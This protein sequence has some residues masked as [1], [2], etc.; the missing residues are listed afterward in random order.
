MT[1]TKRS[2]PKLLLATVLSSMLSACGQPVTLRAV[3]DFCL[4][5][6]HLRF[7]VA[8]APG[9][10]DPGNTLDTDETVKSIIKHNETL[11][12][13]CAGSVQN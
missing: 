13:V 4:L 1:H 12:K 9:S 7:T 8:D 11:D 6:E 10:N 2:M 5:D 3:S